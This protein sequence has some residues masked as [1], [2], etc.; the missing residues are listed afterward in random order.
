MNKMSRLLLYPYGLLD[1]YATTVFGGVVRASSRP[2]DP[3]EHHRREN[4]VGYVGKYDADRK[5]ESVY[6]SK[7]KNCSKLDRSQLSVQYDN[8]TESLTHAHPAI[9]AVEKG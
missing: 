8:A 3:S 9:N 1:F 6:A 4:S 5:Y 7:R 2:T